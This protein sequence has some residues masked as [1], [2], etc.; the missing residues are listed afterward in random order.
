MLKSPNLSPLRM[1]LCRGIQLPLLPSLPSLTQCLYHP[2]LRRINTTT[3]YPSPVVKN[4][5]LF[6]PVSLF[7]SSLCSI[8]PISNG[9]YYIFFD[10]IK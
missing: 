2:S 8:S 5:G 3:V 10:F 6:Y 4:R 7:D 9:S 1:D